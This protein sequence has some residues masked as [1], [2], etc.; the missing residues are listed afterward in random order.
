M[1]T[2][3]KPYS[4]F[5]QTCYTLAIECQFYAG[6]GKIARHSFAA[7]RF[8][9]CLVA[10]QAVL[11]VRV[12]ARLARSAGGRRITP[13][14]SEPH[15]GPAVSIIVPVLDER[16]RLAP[17]LEGLMAHGPEVGEILVIDGGS[18]DGTQ[19]LVRAFSARDPRVRLLAAGPLPAGWNGKA[20]SLQVGLERADPSLPW[21]LTMDADVRPTQALAGALLAHARQALVP[22]L[23]VATLQELEG[24]IEGLI[25]PALLTTLVYRFGGPGRA[26]HR[27]AAVQANGQCFLARREALLAC[28]AFTCAR[29]S[30]CEDVTVARALVTCGYPVGFYETENLVSVKMYENWRGTWGNWPRSLPMR[31]QFTRASSVIGLCEVLLVQALPLPLLL[32]LLATPRRPGQGWMLLVSGLLTATRLGVLAG[33]ARAYRRPPWSYWLS[34]LCDLPVAC[35]LWQSMLQRRHVWRGRGLVV[36]GST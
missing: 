10:A 20:W 35:R 15:T 9:S 22:V 25:H 6:R 3:H 11:G 4:Y 5:V 31:D 23:S 33:T 16:K 29:A 19:D 32:Y 1:Q 8:L 17:C 36:G 34:P 12:L 18:T 24:V 26:C 28:R 30:R 14:R 7:P 13:A 2:Y 21:I 27:V